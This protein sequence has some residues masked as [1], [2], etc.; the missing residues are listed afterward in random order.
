[1]KKV[2]ACGVLVF[3]DAP[4]RAF[5]LMK[6]PYRYDLPKG[7]ARPGETEEQCALRELEEET[8]ILPKQLTL[9][10]DFRFETTYYPRECGEIV[11][12]TLVIFIGWLDSD[13]SINVNPTEHIGFEWINWDPPHPIQNPSITPLL[14]R[15]ETYFNHKGT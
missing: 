6:H 15:V 14:V 2:K 5:L 13:A 1:M 3:R 10:P 4:Q 8:G 12:K 7:H 11:K 9:E